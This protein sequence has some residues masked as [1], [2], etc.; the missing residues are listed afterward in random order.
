MDRNRIAYFRQRQRN[1]VY[2]AIVKALEEAAH[3]RG[4]KRKDIAKT[5]GKE[6][7]QISRWLSG[8]ANWGLDTISDL[9]LAVDAELNVH[10]CPFEE[11]VKSRPN[12][13][14]PL[15]EP[16][17]FTNG[18]TS[19]VK[20]VEVSCPSMQKTPGSIVRLEQVS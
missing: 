7:S 15:S 17:S 3:T 16:A 8:P 18:A 14:H 4:I 20:S 13:F 2:E 1:H 9:L 6:P 5:L 12:Y 19:N 11:K 10:V